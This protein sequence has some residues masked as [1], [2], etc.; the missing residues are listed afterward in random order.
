MSADP[1]PKKP[2]TSTLKKE[3]LVFFGSVKLAII[4]LLL[5]AGAS[6]IGTVLPQDQGPAVVENS[7]FPPALKQVLL[8]IKAYDVYHAFW[9]N[10]LL[11]LLFLNLAVC[12]YLR[13]PPTW[14]RYQMK[15]P[16]TPPVAGLQETVPVAAA[17]TTLAE[18]AGG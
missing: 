14:R 3:S 2:Q 8:T 13:F 15:T 7:A 10:F 18:Y 12:T 17:P 11:A 16:P 9:F 1:K 4:L 6:V 5:V